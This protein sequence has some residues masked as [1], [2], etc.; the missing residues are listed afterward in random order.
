MC[1]VKKEILNFC[2][3]LMIGS[4]DITWNVELIIKTCFVRGTIGIGCN[5]TFL[6]VGL[7][8]LKLIVVTCFSLL[9]RN[10]SLGAT[11]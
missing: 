4:A 7:Q 10:I 3:T 6:L 5:I 2:L 8:L 9:F 1:H 11:E